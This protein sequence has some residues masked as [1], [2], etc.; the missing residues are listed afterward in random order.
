MS[1]DASSKPTNV[2]R[3]MYS[4]CQHTGLERAEK[5][6][7]HRRKEYVGVNLVRLVTM[8]VTGV[9]RATNGDQSHQVLVAS[10]SLSSVAV[11]SYCLI[12]I[13]LIM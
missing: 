9:C 11:F 5:D 12:I 8:A 4:G 13:L 10:L 3:H 7:H 2:D 6:L 1:P